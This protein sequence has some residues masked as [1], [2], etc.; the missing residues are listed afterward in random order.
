LAISAAFSPMQ[1][2]A[3]I[4]FTPRRFSMAGT[5]CSSENL[6]S[7]FFLGRPRCDIRITEP[8]FSSTFLIVG[9]AARIRVSSVTSPFSLRGT[10]K[11]T[12]MIAR[13]PLKS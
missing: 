3:N 7:G 1:S 11:S 13:L 4:T 9:I 12:R 5:I 10:L 2:P 6:G 8:P